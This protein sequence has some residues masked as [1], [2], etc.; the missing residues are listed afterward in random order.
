MCPVSYDV[1][2]EF[3][4]KYRRI[5]SSSYN[6]NDREDYDNNYRLV[7]QEG[8]E[9]FERLDSLVEEYSNETLE[10]GEA[11]F[12][13]FKEKFMAHH[14]E[15][16]LAF[17]ELGVADDNNVLFFGDATK[18][19]VEYACAK[20]SRTHYGFVKTPH[21]GTKTHFV[22][23]LPAARYYAISNCNGEKFCN[24]KI[25]ALYDVQY[26]DKSIFVCTNNGNCEIKTNGCICK[27][28][29]ENYAVCGFEKYYTVT[30]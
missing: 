20:Y 6:D 13:D 2:D 8:N 9:A 15:M 18:A 14:N 25:T 23:T 26:G 11:V 27:S 22:S 29:K 19:D 7:I 28:K 17:H 3:C 4:S 12:A 24:S 21:H 1:I 5:F 30:L 16:S 10:L